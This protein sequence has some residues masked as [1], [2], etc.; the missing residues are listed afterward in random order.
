MDDTRELRVT[1]RDMRTES[2]EVTDDHIRDV[3]HRNDVDVLD[4]ESTL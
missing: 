4:V 1:I 2:P 3:F